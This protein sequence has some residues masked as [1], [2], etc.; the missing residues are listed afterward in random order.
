M[1]VISNHELVKIF[2]CDGFCSHEPSEL[3][4]EAKKVLLNINTLVALTSNSNVSLVLMNHQQLAEV[5]YLPIQDIPSAIRELEDHN[6]L[7]QSADG[8]LTL[9]KIKEAV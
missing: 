7:V 2:P 6:I 9:S 8:Y 1:N 3:S 5:T 4:P